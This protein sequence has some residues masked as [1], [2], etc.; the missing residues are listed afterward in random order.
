MIHNCVFAAVR[1]RHTRRVSAPVRGHPA[2]RGRA[3]RNAGV[4]SHAPVRGIR[5]LSDDAR[6]QYE[7]QVMPP[8]GRR[9]GAPAQPPAGAPPSRK[10]QTRAFHRQLPRLPGS[11]AEPSRRDVIANQIY[12]QNVDK[13][14]LRSRA[15]ENF[16]RRG[17]IRKRGRS[18]PSCAPVARS[19]NV[20]PPAKY[21]RTFVLLRA[22]AGKN[23][24]IAA[25]V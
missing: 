11:G 17:V 25:C 24:P 10:Q 18:A 13:I 7:F 2:D 8:E 23:V 19:D 16:P 4:S 20:S 12:P 22:P 21:G 6:S 5:L 9:R 3:D 14:C 1:R 15:A